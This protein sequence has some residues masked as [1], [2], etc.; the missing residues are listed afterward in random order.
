M[1]LIVNVPDAELSRADAVPAVTAEVASLTCTLS[2]PLAAVTANEP[3]I[4]P[5]VETVTVP[6]PETERTLAAKSTE[7][8][9]VPVSTATG[10]AER[11]PRSL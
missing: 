2:C 6:V 4:P 3:V 1:P 8:L 7:T 10:A 5:S 9:P 11:S